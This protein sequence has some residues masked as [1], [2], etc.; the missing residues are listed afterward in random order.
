MFKYQLASYVLRVL[1]LKI[2]I[3]TIQTEK[4]QQNSATE[5]IT[6]GFKHDILKNYYIMESIKDELA[7]GGSSNI[8]AYRSIVT[9]VQL[10]RLIAE[11]I[12]LDKSG[13]WREGLM[14]AVNNSKIDKSTASIVSAANAITLLV[15]AQ[16]G[17][18]NEDLRNISI[19]GANLRNGR[20]EYTDFSGA[21]LSRVNLTNAKVNWCYL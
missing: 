15:A 6:I 21:D 9:D 1:P 4:K 11:S 20:F 5:S 17:F 13:L 3:K 7:L 12:R 14:K 16:R 8:L 10:L 18:Y 19:E 2:E